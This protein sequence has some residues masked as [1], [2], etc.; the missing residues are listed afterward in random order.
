MFVGPGFRP[1]LRGQDLVVNGYLPSKVYSAFRI[2]N[3]NATFVNAALG[4]GMGTY[5]DFISRKTGRFGTGLFDDVLAVATQLGIKV[6]VKDMRDDLP[7]EMEINENMFENITL[8]D[9]QVDAIKKCAQYQNGFIRKPTGGGKTVDLA[10]FALAF[11]NR[12]DGKPAKILYL[13]DR[14]GLA[15]QTVK[16]FIEY[17]IKKSDITLITGKGKTEKNPSPYEWNETSL[18]N[19]RIVI[20]IWQNH[21]A[22]LPH[23]W[24]FDAVFVDE[25]HHSRGKV[26]QKM[27]KKA[28]NARVRI[29][30][31]GTPFT[32]ELIDDLQ[33]KSMFGSI[34]Y[35]LE[36]KELI[37]REFLVKPIIRFFQIAR[38]DRYMNIANGWPEIYDAGVISF[39]YRN[40]LIAEMA[41]GLEGKTLILFKNY[42]HG[43]LIM[44]KLGIKDLEINNKFNLYKTFHKSR[45]G[46]T[47]VKDLFYVDGRFD[48]SVREKA[49]DAFRKTDNAIIVASGIFDEGIDFPGI[50]S[51]VIASGGKSFVKTIQKLG[52]ALRPNNSGLVHVF[53]FMDMSHR[54]LRKHSDSRLGIW[55]KEG[56]KIEIVKITNKDD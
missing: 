55:Q 16:R 43:N 12:V 18:A 46:K 11:Q 14:V 45:N 48:P 7:V 4:H 50:N 21:E 36:T 29:G 49:L 52:R 44:D 20:A 25:S 8:R 53:D 27:L 23:M 24:Q 1:A 40:H 6:E 51:L 5:K 15:R 41:K 38:N 17:G 28:I 3:P 56:H 13:M 37:D 31:S 54:I 34:I 2:K 22:L 35:E 30:V 42:D 47:L 33:R 39:D 10:A 32:G 9:Y 26:M 19:K